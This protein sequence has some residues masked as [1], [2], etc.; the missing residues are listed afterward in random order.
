MGS[1]CP[2]FSLAAPLLSV[3]TP[4]PPP[5][6]GFKATR[7]LADPEAGGVVWSLPPSI[8]PSRWILRWMRPGGGG[9]VPDSSSRALPSPLRRL[10][11]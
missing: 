11:Q 4:P 6:P 7:R 1:I 10:N 9:P 5:V 8:H 3:P 2:G